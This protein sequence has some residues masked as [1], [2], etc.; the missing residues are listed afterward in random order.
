MGRAAERELGLACLRARLSR[1][2]SGHGMQP[3]KADPTNH[4]F[5]RVSVFFVPASAG[6]V[7]SIPGVHCSK[8]D[9]SDKIARSM[10][11]AGLAL[12]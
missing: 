7:N 4:L 9:K 1:I 3:T 11:S 5:H 12:F 8:R 10:R 2:K 6:I